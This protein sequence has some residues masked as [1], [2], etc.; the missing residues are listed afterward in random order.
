MYFSILSPIAVVIIIMMTVCVVICVYFKENF[1]GLRN[2]L[3]KDY[4]GRMS[5]PDK[6]FENEML[7]RQFAE[8]GP[9]HIEL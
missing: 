7:R 8:E 2:L 4:Q 5:R 6:D 3:R 9:D 1:K